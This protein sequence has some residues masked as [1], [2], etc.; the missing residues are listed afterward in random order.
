MSSALEQRLADTSRHMH[1]LEGALRTPGGGGTTPT[2]RPATPTSAQR[3]LQDA[4]AGYRTRLQALRSGGGGGTADTA[5]GLCAELLARFEEAEAARADAAAKVAA[6]QKELDAATRMV[7]QQ[8]SL[9][10]AGLVGRGGPRPSTEALLAQHTLVMRELQAALRNVQPQ[11]ELSALSPEIQDLHTGLG[12]SDFAAAAADVR[13]RVETL[14]D[15]VMKP[16]SPPAA[17]AAPAAHPSEE[18]W[19]RRAAGLHGSVLQLLGLFGGAGGQHRSG[20]AVG[21][22]ETLAAASADVERL[23]AAAHDALAGLLA[24]LGRA[25]EVITGER[26]GSGGGADS[27]ATL[28]GAVEKINA[29]ADKAAAELDAMTSSTGTA[30]PA[31]A[32]LPGTPGRRAPVAA[33]IAKAHSQWDRRLAAASSLTP[34]S[35]PSQPP[36]QSVDALRAKQLGTVAATLLSALSPEDAAHLAGAEA[37]ATLR[38]CLGHAD[39][40][41]RGA[42]D[43]AQEAADARARAAAAGGRLSH[44]DNMLGEILVDPAADGGSGDGELSSPI[45][46]AKPVEAKLATL[47]GLYQEKRDRLFELEDKLR[48]CNRTVN[49]LLA[50]HD[51]S[52]VVLD[53]LPQKMAVLQELLDDNAG[54]GGRR[55]PDEVSDLSSD[56]ED[57]DVHRVYGLLKSTAGDVMPPGV[58]ARSVEA[59]IAQLNARVRGAEKRAADLDTQL[60]RYVAR[61]QSLVQAYDHRSPSRRHVHLGDLDSPAD[62]DTPGL[63]DVE[64]L[65]ETL[66]RGGGIGGVPRRD[67]LLDSVEAD[68]RAIL[69]HVE[70]MVGVPPWA[71]ALIT[72]PRRVGGAGGGDPSAPGSGSSEGKLQA[73][74]ARW[75][76]VLDHH[77]SAGG[78][79][80]AVAHGERVLLKTLQHV[81]SRLRAALSGQDLP[82]HVRAHGGDTAAHHAVDSVEAA[83]GELD[84]CT[85]GAAEAITR[86]GAERTRVLATM[87]TVIAA[88]QEG[89]TGAK[90]AAVARH[91]EAASESEVVSLS[92]LAA[93]WVAD[94]VGRYSGAHTRLQRLSTTVLQTAQTVDKVLPAAAAAAAA[95][96]AGGGGSAEARSM[97]LGKRS[98]DVPEHVLQEAVGRLATR[99]AKARAAVAAAAAQREADGDED[100]EEDG[101]EEG[102]G[103]GG[104]RPRLRALAVQA[105]NGAGVAQLVSCVAA[106]V[107]AVESD[108]AALRKEGE[109]ARAAWRRLHDDVTRRLGPLVELLPDQAEPRKK[110][111]PG[112]AAAAASAKG[113]S[114]SP[115]LSAAPAAQAAEA[116][117]ER[118]EGKKAHATI[119]TLEQQVRE[120]HRTQQLTATDLTGQK[121]RRMDLE[122]RLKSVSKVNARAAKEMCR[123]CAL[124]GVSAV[125][126]ADELSTEVD[127]ALTATA[128]FEST[129][130]LAE[131]SDD[132]CGMREKVAVYCNEAEEARV[133]AAKVELQHLHLLNAVTDVL[134]VLDLMPEAAA[135]A[136]AASPSSSS[137]SATS[138][139]SSGSSVSP[140]AVS[141]GHS[142]STRA[143]SNEGPRKANGGGSSGPSQPEEWEILVSGVAK[144]LQEVRDGRKARARV[145]ECEAAVDAMVAGILGGGGGAVAIGG[146]HRF[147]LSPLT[148]E[149]RR[150]P[151]PDRQQQQQDGRVVDVDG[152]RRRCAEVEALFREARQSVEN[153]RRLV[154]E[155]AE[156][157]QAFA[158]IDSIVSGGGGFDAGGGG[159]AVDPAAT[160]DKVHSK[161]SHLIEVSASAASEKA[162]LIR[163]NL[164]LK[165]GAEGLR[166]DVDEMRATI[167][168]AQE[169]SESARRKLEA[170]QMF[171]AYA[172][173]MVDGS[174]EESG[175]DERAADGSDDEGAD[176]DGGF[177]EVTAVRAYQAYLTVRK[178]REALRRRV[179]ELENESEGAQL[180]EEFLGGIS[181][182]V[183]ALEGVCSDVLLNICGKAGGEQGG[184]GPSRSPP[185]RPDGNPATIIGS[186]KA[187]E[188]SLQLFVTESSAGLDNLDDAAACL[189]D[190]AAEA[191]VSLPADVERETLSIASA[192]RFLETS[193]E[194]LREGLA[195]R[196][197]REHLRSA[198]G[199]SGH[200]AEGGGGDGSSRSSN[201]SSSSS[202]DE[203]LREQQDH[204]SPQRRPPQHPGQG[205]PR[206]PAPAL[207]SAG[208]G[209]SAGAGEMTAYERQQLM[210]QPQDVSP[211]RNPHGA[212]D[213]QIYEVER[214]M[215]STLN[216]L[217]EIAGSVCCC[218]FYI[219]CFLPLHFLP[220]HRRLRPE[221][222]RGR[223]F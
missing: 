195:A 111:S 191:D 207:G 105:P 77:R 61:V 69:P 79:A 157:A 10:A 102:G 140:R 101:D 139:S 66:A 176:A 196:R 99:A 198:G 1:D 2:M 118:D 33:L 18:P 133:R 112:K 17:A 205:P 171:V 58:S 129:A 3:R 86:L 36:Q 35:Q 52:D 124:V 28:A 153:E 114:P 48:A 142:R 136:A 199:A 156:A 95:S 109:R 120:L 100:A 125:P 167:R 15:D 103:G 115:P 9:V 162:K 46:R 154:D 26:V 183:V 152:L 92:Q 127:L 190:V 220:T 29:F 8:Q 192:A 37:E 204:T 43:A 67:A 89:Q 72:T 78:G 147:S 34:P 98:E 185:A 187:I 206:H 55:R 22:S 155:A 122:G 62:G 174:D 75:R 32:A 116:R 110:S 7:R 210:A 213:V 186:L 119:Q 149:G 96:P 178:D 166:E 27:F 64:A 150:S 14:L 172:K 141:S 97:S 94:L 60:R 91:V 217:E 181:A 76:R 85:A 211:P 68:L 219:Y 80:A 184:R 151:S 180:Q 134:T 216:K 20:E 12:T 56:T 74:L 87:H 189:Q 170:A 161:V 193:L 38:A 146:D 4:A 47:H 175:D 130:R 25:A 179:D 63:D 163:Q 13:C 108:R 73:T 131:T 165:Q 19:Q 104:W 200:A 24:R 50:Q 83:V 203:H 30:V 197:R 70:S 218:L 214:S 5:E 81:A 160:A 208:G 113:R 143:A 45:L 158:R 93:A 138:S 182:K 88:A 121:S 82:E 132:V 11:R 49:T 23:S 145:E 21:L 188:R 169:A 168:E 107:A 65:L 31:G 221:T 126:V 84:R 135:A 222:T 148:T 44:V 106:R 164:E 59:A 90:A 212:D 223:R 177:K 16:A 159:G 57:L 144:L 71:S 201:N 194:A 39:R 40:L 51:R 137:T 117:E 209:A 54:G 53:P 41:R 42:D 173:E 6:Q 202:S 128:L 215:L 123:L